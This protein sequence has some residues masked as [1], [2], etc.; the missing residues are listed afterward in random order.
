MKEIIDK[1]EQWVTIFHLIIMKI[2]D[3]IT[4]NTSRVNKAIVIAMKEIK[5]KNE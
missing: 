2:Q 4:T 1:N 3:N 5:V